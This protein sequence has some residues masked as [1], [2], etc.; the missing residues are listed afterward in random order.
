M[1]LAT[2]PS[3]NIH[4]PAWIE[5]LRRRGED[6]SSYSAAMQ[7][8][9]RANANAYQQQM[10]ALRFIQSSRPAPAVPHTH[11]YMLNGRMVT[12]TTLGGL[13]NCQ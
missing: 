13:T 6:C 11:T 5:A 2:Y 8:A 3:H 12:C 1:R 7:A 9:A 10:D 4:R